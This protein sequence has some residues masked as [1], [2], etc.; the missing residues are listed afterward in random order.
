M[1]NLQCLLWPNLQILTKL[2]FPANF[3][4]SQ[5]LHMGLPPAEDGQGANQTQD[6]SPPCG[7]VRLYLFISLLRDVWHHINLS[8]IDQ[9]KKT[10][11][12]HSSS[13]QKSGNLKSKYSVCPGKSFLHLLVPGRISLWL[14]QVKSFDFKYAC[15]C[16]LSSWQKTGQR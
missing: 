8:N 4:F 15:V 13:V 7:Q 14:D 9:M 2:D 3:A 11:K 12:S 16:H 5:L 1:F 10:K 6:A